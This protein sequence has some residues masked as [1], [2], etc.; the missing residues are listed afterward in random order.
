MALNYPVACASTSVMPTITPRSLSNCRAIST[1]FHLLWPPGAKSLV[2][3][4]NDLLILLLLI[5][6]KCSPWM[7]MDF[8][9]PSDRQSLQGQAVKTNSGSS[10]RVVFN[11]NS[12]IRNAPLPR[13]SGGIWIT[14]VGEIETEVHSWLRC[15][16]V[17]VIPMPQAHRL[18]V[19]RDSTASRPPHLLLFPFL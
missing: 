17:E 3:Y 7:R 14:S 15:G 6:K 9:F 5:R 11:E 10:P 19:E 16:G 8:I 18:S 1:W 13:S 12:N 4:D 2:S